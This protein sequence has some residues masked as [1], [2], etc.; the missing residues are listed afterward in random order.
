MGMIRLNPWAGEPKQARRPET[1]VA[2]DPSPVEIPGQRPDWKYYNSGNVRKPAERRRGGD[3]NSDI[4]QHVE[5][6]PMDMF[7]NSFPRETVQ[8]PA[9]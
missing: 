1:F 4:A 9:I 6:A 2:I 5:A 3:N 7:G 8:P